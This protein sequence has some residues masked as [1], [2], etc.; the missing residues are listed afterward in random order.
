M[1]KKNKGKKQVEENIVNNN[2]EFWIKAVY[3]EVGE[4]G[5]MFKNFLL[6]FNTETFYAEYIIPV[7]H[8]IG[9][10]IPNDFNLYHNYYLGF[11]GKNNIKELYS[12]LNKIIPTYF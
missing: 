4:G 5:V 2:I 9:N 6:A 7:E 3:D 10:I 11:L 12:Y 8:N 1:T